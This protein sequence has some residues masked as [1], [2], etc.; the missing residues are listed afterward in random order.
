MAFAR[1]ISWVCFPHLQVAKE[2][3]GPVDGLY[4]SIRSIIFPHFAQM[5]FLCFDRKEENIWSCIFWQNT[6][7]YFICNLK[8]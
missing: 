5:Q 2:V 8:P 1:H 7:F 3:K 4:D 6:F